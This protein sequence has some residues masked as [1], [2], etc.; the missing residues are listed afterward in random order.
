YEWAF[1]L[2]G[3]DAALTLS[4][5]DP[6]ILVGIVDSGVS[7]VPDLHG[8]VAETFWDTRTNVSADDVVG[9]GTFVSSVIGAANDDGIGLAGFCAACRLAVYKAIPLPDVQIATGI[10]RLTDAHVRIIN[11]SLVEPTASQDIVDAI[12][13]ALAAGVLVIGASGNEGQGT[14]DFPASVVQPA[15]G[16]ASGGIAVVAAHAAGNRPASPYLGHPRAGLR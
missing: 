15:N 11:L 5:G 2:V 7:N 1:H 4:K 9:H 6:S 3:A 14:V 12:N 16:A 8:K 13:Y 10:Q